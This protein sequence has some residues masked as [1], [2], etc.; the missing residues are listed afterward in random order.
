MDGIVKIVLALKLKFLLIFLSMGISYFIEHKAIKKADPVPAIET[1][2]PAAGVGG[3][4]NIEA[5]SF[6]RMADDS[7]VSRPGSMNHFPAQPVN[8]VTNRPFTTQG[9]EIFIVL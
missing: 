4:G 3:S 2:S 6:F 9:L 7:N 5:G 1:V 8:H